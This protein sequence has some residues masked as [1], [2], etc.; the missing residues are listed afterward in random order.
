MRVN[1]KNAC[2]L[3]FA[4]HSWLQFFDQP[5]SDVVVFEMIIF[6]IYKN[7]VTECKH[8][9]VPNGIITFNEELENLSTAIIELPNIDESSHEEA[10]SI[11]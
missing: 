9:I 4:D 5:Q 1:P 6:Q 8:G 11:L 2:K 7:L 3:G 10:I